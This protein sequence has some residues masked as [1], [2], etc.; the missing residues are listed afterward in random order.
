MEGGEIDGVGLAEGLGNAVKW[1]NILSVGIVGR[2]REEKAGDDG[3]D[4]SGEGWQHK[5]RIGTEW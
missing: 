3:M 4:D 5:G 2:P 1:L